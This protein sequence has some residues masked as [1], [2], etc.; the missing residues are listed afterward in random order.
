MRPT[1]LGIKQIY[2]LNV[3]TLLC[4]LFEFSLDEY[5]YIELKDNNY[6]S[7]L[8]WTTKPYQQTRELFQSLNL[9]CVPRRSFFRIL[10]YYA[11]DITDIQTL[12]KLLSVR[13][14]KDIY[15]WKAINIILTVIVL[16]GQ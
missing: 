16:R 5:I 1:L 3:I 4:N 7:Y 12:E 14:F 11:T 8:N 6:N 13:S 2:P 9:T 15:R 10:N